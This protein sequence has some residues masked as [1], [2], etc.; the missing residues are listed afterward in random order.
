[1]H[2]F[3]PA[4]QGGGNGSADGLTAR[5]DQQAMSPTPDVLRVEREFLRSPVLGAYMTRWSCSGDNS[6]RRRVKPALI[7]HSR[8][9]TNSVRAPQLLLAMRTPDGSGSSSWPSCS[10][11]AFSWTPSSCDSSWSPPSWRWRANGSGTTRHGSPS[12]S[13]TDIEGQRLEQQLADEELAAMTIS[14]DLNCVDVR[15]QASRR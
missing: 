13:P 15:V 3:I 6:D 14:Q 10:R 9:A 4:P 5:R 12:T 8:H 1:M 2:G 11:P 7:K